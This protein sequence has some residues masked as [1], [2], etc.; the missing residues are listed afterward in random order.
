MPR[1]IR[2][3]FSK[4]FSAWHSLH[5]TVAATVGGLLCAALLALLGRRAWV[6]PLDFHA[7]L[8]RFLLPFLLFAGAIHVDESALREQGGFVALLATAG[9]LI[10]TAFVGFGAHWALRLA[11]WMISMPACLVFGALIAPTDPVA[12]L[13]I[14][15]R[16]NSPRGLSLVVGAESLFND[17]VAVVTFTALLAAAGG[18]RG[19]ADGGAAAVEN[20]HA[21]DVPS[22][23]VGRPAGSAAARAGAGASG[24]ARQGAHPRRGLR[25][26]PVLP[27]RAGLDALR[28]ARVQRSSR[29]QRNPCAAKLIP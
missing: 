27:A 23:D 9:V 11:G 22:A 10:A 25:R 24:R 26:G 13:P 12:V 1:L 20:L 6:E 29:N 18:E 7:L 4:A 21:G 5:P 3:A 17:G 2:E 14:L 15:R 16:V 8:L 28:A 19:P